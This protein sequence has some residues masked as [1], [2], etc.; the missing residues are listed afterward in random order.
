MK[1]VIYRMYISVIL[2]LSDLLLKLVSLASSST[3]SI[4]TRIILK[5]ND[6]KLLQQVWLSQ[7]AI[8]KDI[9]WQDA[10]Y[11]FIGKDDIDGKLLW[12][13][14][15]VGFTNRVSVD[16]GAGNCICGNTANLILFHKF[17]G[18]MIDAGSD[19]LKA[20]KV[21]YK[22][23]HSYVSEPIFIN[24]M[25]T[26]QTVNKVLK[27]N[28]VP[29]SFD[30]LSIDIDSIDLFIADGLSFKPRI[31]VVEFNNLW[32][33]DESY[34]VPNRDGFTRELDDF[35]YGG[36]SLLAFEKIFKAKGYRIAGIASSGFDAFFVTDTS[37]FA[38]IPHAT[39]QSLYEQSPMWKQKHTESL[40]NII[41]Q[42]EWVKI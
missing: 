18:Y 22:A 37:E 32:G 9:Q 14:S 15:R 21:I 4:S 8:D 23:L 2:K 40:N 28:G 7:L 29:E 27:D 34:S 3:R 36:A 5:Y 17:K 30:L 26:S 39:I 35:L 19:G 1:K 20:G 31:I 33:P 24:A 38:H 11:S 25:L 12:L 13:F 16:I 42:K 6:T 10:C 41:R